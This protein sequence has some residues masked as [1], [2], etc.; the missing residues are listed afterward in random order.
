M[1]N[2]RDENTRTKDFRYIYANGL[3]LQFSGSDVML[4]FGNKEDQGNPNQKFLEEIGVMMTH[5]TAKALSQ[6]LVQVIEHYE[7]TTGV[8]I[9]I[10]QAR[11]DRVEAMLASLPPAVKS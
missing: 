9:P 5:V 10:E 7:K 6:T 8:I 1:S 3:A 2:S 11:K 4:V